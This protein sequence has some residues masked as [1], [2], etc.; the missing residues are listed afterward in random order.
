[1]GLYCVLLSEAHK[2]CANTKE[3]GADAIRLTDT[4]A[5]E[6]LYD[7]PE[8]EYGE[9]AVGGIRTRTVRAG[10][11]LEVEAFPLIAIDAR[12]KQERRRRESSPAQ[13]NLNLKNARKRMRRLAETNF[14]AGDLVVH[15]T[16]NYGFIDRAF[17]NAEDAMKAME[18]EGFPMDEDDARRII[19]NFIA[20]IRRLIK[21]RGGDPKEFKYIYVIESTRESRNDDPNPMPARFHYHMIISSM[22]ILTIDDVNAL[23]DHGYTKAEPLDFRFN[24]LEGLCN[25]ISKQRKFSRRWAHSKN[26]K[27]PDIKTSDR[28]ISRRRAAAIAAD[29]QANAREIMEKIYPGY[30]LEQAEVKYSDFVAGAYIYARLRKRS[31][32][33]RQ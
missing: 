18:A 17:C 33:R 12:A 26:L 4:S 29:V 7:L 21:R 2:G 23:W 15:P 16:F 19:K 27:E 31:P 28:K 14:K 5:Y 9:K 11:S 10:D 22:G 20:R 1:M 25:Y 32:A 30:A 3:G 6:I 13:K 8:G 24:G